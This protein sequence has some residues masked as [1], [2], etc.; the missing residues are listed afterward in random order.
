MAGAGPGGK[1]VGRLNLKVVPETSGFVAK[2][3]AFAE[4]V[5]SQVK[6]SIPVSIDDSS[7]MDDVSRLQARLDAMN[8]NVPVNA[9]LDSAGVKIQMVVLINELNIMAKAANPTIDVDV[10]SGGAIAQMTVLTRGVGA[11]ASSAG[12]MGRQI[13][14]WGPLIFVAA[15]AIAA[16]GPA[17]A[18]ILPLVA[19]LGLAVGVIAFG[20]DALKKTLAPIVKG[21][22][23]MRAAI[24]SALTAGLNPLV[25]TFVSKVMPVIKN[26]LVAFA[27][28]MNGAM[29]SLFGFLNSASGISLLGQF[30]TGLATAMKPFGAL[31]AP[32]AEVFLRLSIA[33]L[34]AL[35]MMGDAL[36]KV[37]TQFAGFLAKGTST[38]IITESMSNLGQVMSILGNLV[39]D[40]FPTLF[41]AV[42]PTIAL[43]SG[44]GATLGAM[45][46]ILK[47][48]FTFLGK[49]PTVLGAF[50]AAL[51]VIVVGLGLFAGVM[52]VVNLVLATN[53]FVLIL[54]GL[55]ALAAG[56][57]YAY[58]KSETFRNIVN[59]V[60]SAIGAVVSTVVGFIVS[61][62]KLFAA[63]LL[64]PISPLLA[65]GAGLVM[66][67]KKSETFR[68]IVS[69]AFN[70]IKSAVVGFASIFVSVLASIV[71]PFAAIVNAALWL[72]DVLFGHSVFPDLLAAIGAFVGVFKAYFA[73]WAAVF[74]FVLGIIK[75]VMTAIWSVIK[76]VWTGIVVTISTAIAL[77][78]AVFS[79]GFGVLRAVAGAVW[80]GIK[81]V[82]MGV[83][84]VIRAA[85]AAWVAG[86]RAV[87]SGGMNAAKA[88]VSAVWNGIKAV[89]TGAIRT[90]LAVVRGVSA[91]AG[92]FRSA[93]NSA[94]SAVTSAVGNIMSFV[95]GVPGKI[96][97]ALTIDLSGAGS[98]LM[99]SFGN[100]IAKAGQAA[101]QKVKDI[102]NKIKGLLPGSPIR[103]GPLTSWNNGGAGKRLME[104]FAYGIGQRQNL[105]VGQV[106]KV[107]RAMDSAFEVPNLAAMFDGSAFGGVTGTLS[108]QIGAIVDNTTGPQPQEIIMN[109]QTGR[110]VMI[111]I[112][113][114]E[115]ASKEFVAAQQNRMGVPA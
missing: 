38:K 59:G 90:I 75:T 105:V 97:S 44:F 8:L 76:T 1:E 91:V 52:A 41:A 98:K 40:V 61:H 31:L 99:T 62:W 82:I 96:K 73:M 108:T 54:I 26:G 5:E 93:F 33:A 27:T 111:D 72:W 4:R 58:K 6:I 66:L 22:G 55:V 25:A 89:I 23:E 16:I 20:F 94:K 95:K 112:A 15:V 13:A 42:G 115:M 69:G 53:P 19:A 45:F 35:Q 28:F 84:N 18:V 102:A 65:I 114:Q 10:D 81:A 51:A 30:F 113:E 29:K 83:I 47:P 14:L 80:N 36:L 24:G 85:I 68:N 12:H 64:A 39:G 32:L 103:W 67:Y 3:K 78:R 50:G 9:N 92:V 101:L 71:A 109:W 21:F 63:I 11:G 77:V 48:V 88:V 2:L 7:V 110:G 74:T 43:L 37:T 46:A 49:Y 56:L 34:P 87:I 104:M 79:A 60:F 70:A 86:V 107:A 17:F 106:Q 100:G 57:V